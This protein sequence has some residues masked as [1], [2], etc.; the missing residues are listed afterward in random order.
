[1]DNNKARIC[2]RMNM[3]RTDI[4]AINSN[5]FQQKEVSLSL[6]AVSSNPTYSTLKIWYK[7]HKSNDN[8]HQRLPFLYFKIYF[9]SL[10]ITFLK[11]SFLV[12]LDY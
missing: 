11:R 2:T 3:I 10:F 8:F 7:K 1:M 4:R 9:T 6:L 5:Y 12:K